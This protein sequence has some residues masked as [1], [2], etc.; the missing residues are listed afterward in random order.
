MKSGIVIET[1][2]EYHGYREAISKSRLA[3][4]SV[5]P[6]YFKWC[7]DNPQ[8]PS[9][10]MVLGS[11]F[12]KIVLE[13]E[14]FYDEFA[15]MPNVD[16]RTTQGKMKYAEF[17]IEADGKTVI[18]QE[19][20]DTIC[21][22]RDSISLLELCAGSHE[23]ITVELVNE[24]VGSTGR[25]AMLRVVRAVAEQDYETILA[26]I[27][28]V[29]QSSQDIRV[30][31]QDLISLYR[32]IL[33]V[34]TS[35]NAREYLDLTESEAEELRE[36]AS[37]FTKETLLY[38]SKLLEEGLSSMQKGTDIRR[39]TA[40]FTLLRMCEPSLSTS[41]E[42][43]LSRVSELERTVDTLR[44]SGYTPGEATVAA[45]ASAPSVAG[46]PSV[47]EKP[48]V[49]VP[50]VK[51]SRKPSEAKAA[52]STPS[53]TQADVGTNAPKRVLKTLRGF[54]EVVERLTAVHPMY[55]SM[56]GDAKAYSL[57]DGTVI[58]RFPNQFKL[59]SFEQLGSRDKLRGELSYLL[60]RDV[61]D[62]EL[63][64]EVARQDAGAGGND[65][66]DEIIESAEET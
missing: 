15:V 62:R 3:N 60:K 13:P 22:M 64:F 18:T 5:C 24:T 55:R 27:N 65:P 31:W 39:I 66:L 42:A 44:R 49:S 46:Q 32:D 12:H 36:V 56:L 61:K 9:E 37:L 43:L 10:D 58:L 38:H 53:T 8:E 41:P 6:A 33:V 25:S 40:E 29:V 63:I 19:Q 54:A 1:N 26:E 52:A 51:T 45:T 59:S 23:R 7:E 30:F 34:R 4:M 35:Q 2:A 57:E 48:P 50:S 11:A 47:E 28:R 16:R 17:I 20:Y 21:G 14:T